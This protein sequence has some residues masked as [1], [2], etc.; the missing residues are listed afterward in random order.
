MKKIFLAFAFLAMC[1]A[2]FSQP[3]KTAAGPV[4]PDPLSLEKWFVGTW[5]CEGTQYG[6]PVGLPE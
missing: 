1:A 5:I 6:S 4:Q 3:A 2:G